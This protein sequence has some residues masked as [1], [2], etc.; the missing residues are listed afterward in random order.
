MM[1][2]TVK[3]GARGEVGDVSR[4]YVDLRSL[5][6]VTCEQISDTTQCVSERSLRAKDGLEGSRTDGKGESL[7]KDQTGARIELAPLPWEKSCFS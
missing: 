5:G 4:G 6:T 3:W 7:G 2:D 1:G